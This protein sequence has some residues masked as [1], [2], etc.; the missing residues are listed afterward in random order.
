MHGALQKDFPNSFQPASGRFDN[1]FCARLCASLC[2]RCCANMCKATSPIVYLF[3]C[4]WGVWKFLFGVQPRRL[5]R[6]F[7]RVLCKVLFRVLSKVGCRLQGAAQGTV[8]P[9]KVLVSGLQWRCLAMVLWSD[10]GKGVVISAVCATGWQDVLQHALLCSGFLFSI[11]RT[12]EAWVPIFRPGPLVAMVTPWFPGW[13][14]C[15]LAWHYSAKTNYSKPLIRHFGKNAFQ[16]QGRADFRWFH[17]FDCN[18]ALNQR[19]SPGIWQRVS[20]CFSME[21]ACRKIPLG[22]SKRL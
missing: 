6:V 16:E 10:A 17:G 22:N 8:S 14:A 5:C 9:C 12:L 7:C 11:V 3:F 4:V 2:A 18:G 13:A 19:L 1:G 15:L 20:M 21:K